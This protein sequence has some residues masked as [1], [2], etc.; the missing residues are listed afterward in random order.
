MAR[1]AA[2][3]PA[4]SGGRAPKPEGRRAAQNAAGRSKT[5]IVVLLPSLALNVITA[6][7]S[8]ERPAGLRSDAVSPRGVPM[9][10]SATRQ[11]PHHLKSAS[12]SASARASLFVALCKEHSN[13]NHR[14]G[15]KTF[16]I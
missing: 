8:M 6:Q 3:S 16:P 9:S 10:R 1:D 7:V 12:A 13:H 14:P 11:P 4:R 15:K 5:V 2:S